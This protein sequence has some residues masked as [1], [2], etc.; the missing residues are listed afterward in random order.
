MAHNNGKAKVKAKS[1]VLT[2]RFTP[3][4]RRIIDE[5]AELCR[6]R[7]SVWVRSILLQVARNPDLRR[8]REPN[9]ETI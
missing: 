7:T 5:R 4:Q 1:E 2:L 9:G 6:V 8:I 3:D